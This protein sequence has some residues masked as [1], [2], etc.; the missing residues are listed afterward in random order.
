MCIHSKQFMK[1]AGLIKKCLMFNVC[2]MH[3]TSYLVK[4]T[5]FTLFRCTCTQLNNMSDKYTKKT[6]INTSTYI[7]YIL[8][9]SDAFILNKYS[10]INYKSVI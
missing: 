8:Q 6:I 7:T 5:A 2:V 4:T 1:P 10:F 3:F 9:V